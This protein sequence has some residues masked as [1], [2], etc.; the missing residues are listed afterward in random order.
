MWYG[1]TLGPWHLLFTWSKTSFCWTL[2]WFTPL[3]PLGLCSGITLPGR[4]SLKAFYKI[5]ASPPGTHTHIHPFPSYL[6]LL[7]SAHTQY[8]FNIYLL[9]L[10]PLSYLK[11][12]F[13]SLCPEFLEQCL[14]H[15][16][17]LLLQFRISW[18][19]EK[20]PASSYRYCDCVLIAWQ[21]QIG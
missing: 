1:L 6:T 3:P 11:C 9:C 2:S 19:D 8:L 4:P 5:K 18:V 16:R 14:A 21:C 12:D 10:L 20:K 7:L 15:S 13:F 17:C